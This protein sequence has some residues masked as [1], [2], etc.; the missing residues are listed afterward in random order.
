MTKRRTK[1]RLKLGYLGPSSPISTDTVRWL[2][3]VYGKEVKKCRITPKK[4]KQ[5]MM[6]EREHSGVVHGRKKDIA[7]IAID[8]I[9]ERPDYYDLLEKYVESKR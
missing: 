7:K 6:V 9:C 2:M 1:K 8:H 4:L 5:G 3:R